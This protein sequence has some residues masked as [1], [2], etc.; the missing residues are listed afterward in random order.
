MV[1]DSNMM[2]SKMCIACCPELDSIDVKLS[3]NWCR[4]MLEER[5]RTS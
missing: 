3:A 2:L 4:I 1:D 5:T